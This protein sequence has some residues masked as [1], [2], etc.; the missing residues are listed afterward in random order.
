MENK[1]E[2]KIKRLAREL[3]DLK[4]NHITV[5]EIDQGLIFKVIQDVVDRE[6]KN[7]GQNYNQIF[8]FNVFDRRD[9]TT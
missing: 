1:R 4:D 8:T 6:E 9:G 3:M 5:N 2:N 7:S